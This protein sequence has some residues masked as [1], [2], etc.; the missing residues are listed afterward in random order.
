MII[1]HILGAHSVSS[2]NSLLHCPQSL[3]NSLAVVSAHLP[4]VL[5]WVPALKHLLD[6]LKSET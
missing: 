6:V 4:G 2:R 1:P 5:D 3:R